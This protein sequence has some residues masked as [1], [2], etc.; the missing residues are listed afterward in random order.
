MGLLRGRWQRCGH[1]LFVLLALVANLFATS[2][3]LLHHLAHDRGQREARAH[4]HEHP[5]HAHHSSACQG[6]DHDEIHPDAL[7]DKFLVVPRAG[8]DLASALLTE[9]F[10]ELV[11][12]DLEL[13]PFRSTSALHSRAPP[14]DSPARAPPLV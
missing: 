4:A 12:V 1:A 14:R 3:P 10:R 5:R 9:R 11:A 13:A 6:D 2:V 8:L 7:H